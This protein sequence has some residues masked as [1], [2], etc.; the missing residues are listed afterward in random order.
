MRAAAAEYGWNVKYGGSA[1]MWRGGCI[2]QSGFLQNIADAFNE[3][4]ALDFLGLNHY[5]KSLLEN[6]MVD[7]RKVAAKAV[8]IGLP[9]PCT[10]SGISF[11]DA[12]TT[13]RLPANM[14]QAQRDY[15]GAHT[16]ER[17]DKPLGEFFHYNWLGH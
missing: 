17:L 14:I 5:F 8:E 16:Y 2:I 4:P 1:L 15:F 11:L 7:W 6:A 9:M 10:L 3:D 13:A 12:Y